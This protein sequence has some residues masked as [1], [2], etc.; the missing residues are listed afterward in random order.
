MKTS[1]SWCLAIALCAAGCSRR[2]AETVQADSAAPPVPVVKV[3][4]AETRRV[5]R[6][7]SVTGSLLAEETV[8]LSSEVPGTLLR[9][10]ADFG[11]RFRKGDIL[12]ELDAREL[13]LQAERSRAALSQAL[14]RVGLSPGQEGSSPDSTPAIRQTLAQ[15][16]D[17][18]SKYDSAAKL[19]G[20]GDISRERYTELEK[21]LRA[22]EAGLQSAR[23]D[24]RMQLAAI[25]G[26][27]AEVKLA[28]KRLG[29]AR[30][31]APFDGSVAAKLISPGQ[32]V[33]EN[34]PLLAIVK[35][36][37]LR[38]RADVAEAAVGAVR[39]GAVITFSTGAAP[40]KVFRA[41]V[42]ELN[43]SLDPRSRSLAV[44]ARLLDSAPVLKPGMFVQ[45]DLVTASQES[46][47]VA[48]RAAIYTVAGLTKV[49]VVSGGAVS[50]RR[51][52]PGREEQGWVEMP[53]GAVKPGDMLAVSNLTALV[54][55]ASVRVSN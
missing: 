48:P 27:G 51:I 5:E 12:A 32:Y 16:E 39:A 31:R 25:Q 43:P 41:T 21:A 44:E 15:L 54:H 22:R 46:A 19:V 8:N 47:V 13:T 50:E 52:V 36:G 11:R 24:L 1:S 7:I 45:V 20:S 40:G 53:A 55:G 2:A 33:K 9:V 29:D 42:T 38:L 23:D 10:N 26:L 34:V 30:I 37:P 49:F 6:S 17:A 35:S 18:R 3:A 4:A 14:A 28:E